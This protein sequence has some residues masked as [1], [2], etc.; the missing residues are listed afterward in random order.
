MPELRT[1]VICVE[2]TRPVSHAYLHTMNKNIKYHTMTS[3]SV[4]DTDVCTENNTKHDNIVLNDRKYD[5]KICIV[6][7]VDRRVVRYT[8][9]L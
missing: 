8:L 3:M 9:T 5:N 1:T 4:N 6:I 2:Q 7:A